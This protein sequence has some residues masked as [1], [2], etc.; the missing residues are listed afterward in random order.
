MNSKVR[1]PSSIVR[2]SAQSQSFCSTGVVPLHWYR[3][4]YSPLSVYQNNSELF[5]EVQTFFPLEILSLYSSIQR[6][7]G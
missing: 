6:L 3:A 2:M 5:C 1:F 4:N 7:R